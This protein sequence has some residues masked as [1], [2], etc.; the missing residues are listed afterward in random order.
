MREVSNVEHFPR[1]VAGYGKSKT[2]REDM[3]VSK[4]K[5]MGEILPEPFKD[6]IFPPFA[7]MLDKE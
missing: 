5:I 7:Q 6:H 1:K 4:R 2:K 3:G